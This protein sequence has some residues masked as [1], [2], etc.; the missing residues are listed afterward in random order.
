MGG[1]KE[2]TITVINALKDGIGPL[3]SAVAT[4]GNL[5]M[6]MTTGKVIEYTNDSGE[7]VK[8]RIEMEPEKFTEKANLITDCFVGFISTLYEKFKQYDVEVETG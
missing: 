6:D 4:Y 8:R 3:M 7:L 5:I 1:V 2:Q